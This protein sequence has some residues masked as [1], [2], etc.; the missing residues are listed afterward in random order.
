MTSEKAEREGWAVRTVYPLTALM[1]RKSTSRLPAVR[2]SHLVYLKLWKEDREGH[3]FYIRLEI[4][5]KL[6]IYIYIKKRAFP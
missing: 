1:L 3:K 5:N 2:D 6:Y 4:L